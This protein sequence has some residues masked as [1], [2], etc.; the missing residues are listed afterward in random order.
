MNV[1]NLTPYMVLKLQNIDFFTG[2]FKTKYT[3]FLI[4]NQILKLEFQT[5]YHRDIL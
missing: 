4:I 5:F 3:F 1:L 2:K